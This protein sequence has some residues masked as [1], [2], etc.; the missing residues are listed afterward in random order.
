M[1]MEGIAFCIILAAWIEFFFS[2][3]WM[4]TLLYAV[5]TYRAFC[6][7]P[8]Q[9]V[10]YHMLA[11][12]L[13]SVLTA[14]G[15]TVLYYPNAD[16]HNLGPDDSAFLTLLP[17]YFVT[18]TPIATIMI[19]NPILYLLCTRKVHTLVANCLSQF[20]KKE[21]SVVDG[22]KIKFLLIILSFYVCWLPNLING[23]I[24][25]SSWDELPRN[26]MLTIWY[27]MAVLNPLQAFFNSMVYRGASL[28]IIVPFR[29]SSPNE[30]TPLIPSNTL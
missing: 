10:L 18:Y 21:R 1:E 12:S 2:V 13:P 25:W 26:F 23:V 9:P 15:L 19:V 28:K 16:C 3:T 14:V 27:T 30:Q 22:V 7:K 29:G 20:T 24:I 8:G 6:R 4:W 11:W 17:N 5:D